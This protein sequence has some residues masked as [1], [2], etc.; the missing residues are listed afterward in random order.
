MDHADYIE[1]LGTF[2]ADQFC[3]WGFALAA[4]LQHTYDQTEIQ[5]LQEA[6]EQEK[7]NAAIRDKRFPWVD[8]ESARREARDKGQANA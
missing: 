7:A 5:H 3:Y 2:I 1:V 4:Q 8:M 6:L